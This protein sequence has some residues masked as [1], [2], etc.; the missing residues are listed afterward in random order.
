M[1]DG[2]T[3][4]GGGDTEA[5]GGAESWRVRLR[6]L[7]RGGIVGSGVL[8][9]GDTVLTCAHVL[10]DPKTEVGVEFPEIPGA[11][12]TTAAVIEGCWIPRRGKD[13]GDLA[14]LRLARPQPARHSAPLLRMAP[15][16]GVTVD[17]C[18]YPDAVRDGAGVALVATLSRKFGERVQ[19]NLADPAQLPERGCSGG[20]VQDRSAPTRVLGLTV[21]RY[22]RREGLAPL[23]LAHMI[24]VDTILTHLPEIRPWVSGRGGVPPSVASR[25]SVREA[26]EVG[27]AE[28]LAQWLS[29]AVPVYATEVTEGSLRE[30]T[31]KRALA[32][33]DRELS[34]EPP[35]PLSRERPATVPPV[36]SLDLAVDT[37]GKPVDAVVTEVAERMNLGEPDARRARE[38]L[39][40]ERMPLTLALLGVNRARDPEALLALCGDFAEYG[41]RL[42]LV[43]LGSGER[44]GER[45]RER[46]KLRHRLGALAER[47]RAVDGR[48]RQLVRDAERLAGMEPP[49][50]TL[51]DLWM[52]LTWLLSAERGGAGPEPERAWAAVET[53]TRRLYRLETVAARERLKAEERYRQRDALRRELEGHRLLTRRLAGRFGGAA[54]GPGAPGR[55]ADPDGSGAPEQVADGPGGEAARGDRDPVPRPSGAEGRV[56]DVVLA[57]EYG[58][59]CDALYGGRFVALSAA[60]LV[61]RYGAGVRRE[62]GWPPLEEP[63]EDEVGRRGEPEPPGGAPDGHAGPRP[64]ERGE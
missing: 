62:L 44:V 31:L 24:P 12:A 2:I 21:T 58:A 6:S 49:D 36:G 7:A 33:A 13:R 45:T 3:H 18:G 41:C 11:A 52:G 53:L 22:V 34:G 5:R 42:L 40:R 57:E 64:P 1:G 46:L 32:L 19:L 27:Y 60:R 28:R 39:R 51:A 14:L 10:A 43:S 59:A 37:R 29:S 9:G 48:V 61:A 20:P 35:T 55:A 63:P 50:G 38:R 47:L 26:V 16:T 4:R 56:E 25:A 8:L 17:L 54:D 15:S 30:R 23:V